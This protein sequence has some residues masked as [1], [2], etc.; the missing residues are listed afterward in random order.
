MFTAASLLEFMPL[1]L[2]G[3]L[4]TLEVTLYSTVLALI[5]AFLA[6]F[7]QLSKFRGLR[8]LSTVYVELFRGTSLLVQLFW[9]Y[10]ALPILFD[11]R[12]PAMVAAVAAIGLNYGAYGSVVVRS[13]ILAV[14]KGQYE[15]ATALN[16]SP[17]IRM[18]KVILPQALPLMLPAFGNLQIELLKGT[19]LV[20]LITLME[21]TYQ[22][23][24]LRSYDSSKTLE[25]FA[26]LLL[27]YF[28]LAYALT[29][30]VR[31]LERRATRGRA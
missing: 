3:A 18:R 26:L 15:A 8:V 7:L 20:Y 30:I 28:V 25:I 1:L 31:L 9:L 19:S 4:V 12:M 22:G 17:A 14:P 10:F 11:I 2:R 27:M 13:S 24:I 21:L 29:W 16:M 5:L 23:M 6:G